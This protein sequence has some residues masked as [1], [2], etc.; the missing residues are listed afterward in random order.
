LVDLVKLL[1][2]TS[3]VRPSKITFS[4]QI[5]WYVRKILRGGTLLLKVS[6]L[7]PAEEPYKFGDPSLSI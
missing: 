3:V 4:I 1:S 2:N 6:E 5:G 7:S